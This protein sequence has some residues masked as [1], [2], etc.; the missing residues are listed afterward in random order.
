M[1]FLPFCYLYVIGDIIISLALY[2]ASMRGYPNMVM[3]GIQ[4]CNV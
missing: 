4:L 3:A 1:L 2:D